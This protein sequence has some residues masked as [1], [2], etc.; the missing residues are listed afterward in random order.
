MSAIP[1]DVGGGGRAAPAGLNHEGA[2][3]SQLPKTDFWPL[4]SEWHSSHSNATWH[5]AWGALGEHIS[6]ADTC[7]RNVPSGNS[8]YSVLHD[9]I[10]NGLVLGHTQGTIHKANWENMTRPF[11]RDHQGPFFLFW[12]CWIQ[13][14]KESKV[15]SMVGFVPWVLFFF[16]S[17]PIRLSL[18]PCHTSFIIAVWLLLSSN[19]VILQMAVCYIPVINEGHINT[20]SSLNLQNIFG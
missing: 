16:I 11:W 17:V 12:S 8:L 9:E 5:R 18:Y 2:R 20:Y 7:F 3:S 1:V 4:D 6:E 13:D 10:L 15:S 19:Q 14:T